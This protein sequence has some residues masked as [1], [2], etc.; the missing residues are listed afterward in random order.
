MMNLNTVLLFSEEP[1]KLIE[2]YKKVLNVKPAWEGGDFTGFK[3]GSGFLGIGPHSKVHGKNTSPERMMFNI[4]VDD[5]EKE[6]KRIKNLKAKVIQEP[7]TP[8]EEAT[9]KIAT[10]ADVDNNFFQI[11]TKME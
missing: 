7:Y 1:K 6:F 11:N 9:I 4:E 3:L 10:F 5:I 2:F 8:G